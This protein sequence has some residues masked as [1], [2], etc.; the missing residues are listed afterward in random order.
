MAVKFPLKMS[1]GTQAKSIEEL[2]E[3]FDLEAVFGY[4]SNGRLAKWLE[5]RYYDEEAGKVRMLDSSLENFKEEL[6]AILGVP[7]I[8]RMD[9][10]IDVRDIVKKNE[11]R[12]HLKKYTTDD[13]ILASVDNV[14]FTQK[15]LTDL[16]KRLDSLE[17]DDE[18]NKIIYLCGESFIIPAKISGIVYR[19]INNP[20]VKFDADGIES[21]I[22]LQDIEC[23]VSDYVEDGNYGAF[24]EAFDNN[25]LLGTKLLKQVAEK[26]NMHAQF[27]LGVHYTDGMGTEDG[28]DLGEA[29]EWFQKAA[30]QGHIDANVW[31]YYMPLLI[32]RLEEKNA[33]EAVKWFK[34]AVEQDSL[35]A[36]I[37]CG[38]LGRCYMQGLGVEQDF[39]KAVLYLKRAVE[40]EEPEADILYYLGWC[41]YSGEGSKQ[42]YREAVK[43]L[44][45]AAELDQVAAQALLAKC[46]FDGEGVEKSYKEAARWYRK[47]AEQEDEIAQAILGN[48]YTAGIGVEP[49]FLEAIKWCRRAAEQ[50]VENAQIQLDECCDVFMESDEKI[51]E[52]YREATEQNDAEAQYYL[53]SCYENGQ[54]TEIDIVE[55]GEWYTKAAAQEHE[56]SREAFWRCMR[57]D[58][59]KI[60]GNLADQLISMSKT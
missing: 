25:L 11:R 60:T 15:E 10:R 7:Y 51:V 34:K 22:D 49:N 47:A 12:E 50:G 45:R 2:R 6:C 8:E 48:L 24:Y 59:S 40:D 17:M 29:N 41:Y 3:H 20:T 38:C 26:G 33:R 39:K 52:Y 5:D 21:G 37:A 18:D 16:L 31:I 35:Y 43:W 32:G 19:G 54:G 42:D 53:G 13:R 1:D 57:S 9:V 55:A 58:L 46:Y 4:Y 28:W 14:A 36:D 44:Q 23:D 56:K 27:L 30:E